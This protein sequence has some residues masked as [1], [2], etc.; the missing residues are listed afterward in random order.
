MN[1]EQLM[2]AL[3]APPEPSAPVLT[4]PATLAE[5][6]AEK[7]A[8]IDLHGSELSELRALQALPAP[9]LWAI[10]SPGP[11]ETYPCLNRE[12][13][14]KQATKIADYVEKTVGERPTINVIPSPW[15]PAEHFEIM[16][17]EWLEDAEATSETAINLHARVAELEALIEKQ[18]TQ[19][20]HPRNNHGVDAHY[21]HKNLNRVLR[22]FESFT[23]DEL[24]RTL[25]RLAKVADEAV[26]SETEFAAVPTPPAP[27]QAEQ[28][29][30]WV[31]QIMEQAQVFASA[32]SLVG[33][34]FDAGDGLEHAKEE[35]QRL[36]ALL[37][38]GR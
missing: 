38:G 4:M 34:Q 27:E 8:S 12:D 29:S 20:R 22:D 1:T 23:P 13:A 26:L 3:A 6:I 32:W 18:T 28:Q 17:G 30:A 24:S 21:F 10:Y 14:E 11:G 5:R 2:Y 16:A 31:E 35:K 9:Q 36:R 7:L 15:E 37:E 19:A 25:A 33:G